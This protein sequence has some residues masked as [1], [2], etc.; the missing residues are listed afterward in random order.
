MLTCSFFSAIVLLSCYILLTCSVLLTIVHFAHFAPL[1][2]IVFFPKFP[3]GDSNAII[4]LLLNL[5]FLLY[6]KNVKNK[7]FIELTFKKD[8]I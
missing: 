5:N 7:Q 3:L 8:I 6:I 4:I 2:H 1:E